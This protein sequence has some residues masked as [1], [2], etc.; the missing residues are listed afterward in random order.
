[1]NRKL[2]GALGALVVLAVG[3]WF[4]ALRDRGD[5]HQTAEPSK[6][7]SKIDL[8]APAPATPEDSPAPKG[9]APAWE[10]D[11]DPEG[12]LRLEGQVVDADG[13]GVGDAEVWLSSVP[14]RSAT[15]EGDG[16]FAFDKL[17]GREYSVSARA[18]KLVGGPVE[19]KLA[20]SSDPVVIRL[21]AGSKLVVSVIDDAAKPIAG[22]DVVVAACKCNGKTS[23]DGQVTLESI[24][25]GWVAVQVS[26]SGYAPGNGFTQIAG[27]GATGSLKVTLHRGFP[28]SGRVIDQRGKPVEKA[29]VT[30]SGVFDIPGGVEPAITDAKGQFTFAALAPGNHTLI[31][32][33]QVHA[34]ARSAP[35]TVGERAVTGVEIVMKQGGTLAGIVVTS[36][37][38]PVP[39]ATVR[40]AG[41]GSQ[42]W[43]VP[44]RQATTDNAGK[45]ELTGLVRAKLKARAES[46]DAA[47][48]IAAVDLTTEVAK[49]DVRLVLDVKGTIAGIVVDETGQ[50]VPE[51]QVNAFP[52]ILGGEAP[53]AISLA[54]MSSAT[55][56]GGGR[57]AI[58]GLPDGTYRVR[59][60]RASGTGRYDWG[61][62]GTK[63]KTGDKDVK[64]TLAA[65]GTIVGKIAIEGASAPPKLAT[66]QHGS[67][68][69][70]TAAADGT[71]RI[72]DVTPGTWDLRVR[73]PEFA[74]FS[75]RDVEVKPGKTT[76]VGTITVTRGRKLTGKV[77]D[78]AGNPVAGA[79]VKTGDMLYSL[80]G[81]EDQM[82]QLEEMSG[83]KT[84]TT[85]QDGRFTMIGLGKKATNVMAEHATKGRSNAAEIPAGTD[86]PPPITLALRGF[87][88]I[89]GKVT[90]QGKPVGGATIT[91]TP[92]GGGAQVQVVQSE[93]DGT[94]TLTR[95]SEGPHVLS[96]MQQSMLSMSFKSTS[97]NV[98][99][100]A[101]KE[102][103]VTIDIP[104]GSITLAVQVKALPSHKVDSAQVFL[105]RGVVAMHDA[106]ELTEAFLGGGVQGMK[107]WFGDG[108]PLPEF[109]EL[110]P[111]SYSVCTIPISGD[112]NDPTFQQRIQEHSQALDVFCKQVK[113]TASPAKQTVVHEVP[114]MKP[115]PEK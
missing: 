16:T 79:K 110:V 84:D 74:E 30:T 17:V 44:W 43:M 27:A 49:K 46:D 62:P 1:M 47:S 88:S 82:E 23:A 26:A 107:F 65:P 2:A 52:D 68:A 92:K 32:T 35:V 45:F 115:L 12:P 41:D 77:V 11:V 40:V 103:K 112:L 56:D 5:P 86:D 31:A 42:M 22:A 100:A 21:V 85:D 59:A 80:Q 4:F 66:V 64:I 6:R 7:S 53:E 98:Q 97:T 33:D 101:G 20:E 78:T 54:G 109:E 61:Q 60:S 50:P 90:S 113:L 28:V 89:T 94:F 36:D 67:L 91:D 71:F 102:T 37:G 114:S 39:Y 3:I 29:H 15:T 48:G 87:G 9:L 76:D 96:A 69:P 57:F 72:V 83:I 63:A 34:P 38:Q 8:Q 10:L 19:Y 70:A 25:P 18:G 95:A 14:P 73:G 58:R 81:A 24:H 106:K 105:F 55:T 104:V 99:V 111:G 75:Q 13:E 93:A 51:V 108:K